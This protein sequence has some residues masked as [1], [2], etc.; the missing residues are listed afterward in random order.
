MFTTDLHDNFVVQRCWTQVTAEEQTN[1]CC[2]RSIASTMLIQQVKVMVCPLIKNV[3]DRAFTKDVCV[4]IRSMDS[5]KKEFPSRL[6]SFAKS[7][8]TYAITIM[9][10]TNMIM[11]PRAAIRATITSRRTWTMQ[12]GMA[13][14]CLVFCANKVRRIRTEFC[15]SLFVHLRYFTYR[16]IAGKDRWVLQHMPH[17]VETKCMRDPTKRIEC[18]G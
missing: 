10:S 2:S 8:N 6:V 12:T 11:P 16:Y 5:T 17:G 3:F 15:L 4:S 1:T 14:P 18:I 7:S 9:S 13:M